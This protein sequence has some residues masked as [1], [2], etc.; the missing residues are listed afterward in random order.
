ME[1]SVKNF[2]IQ[3]ISNLLKTAE[4]NIELDGDCECV[5]G[6]ISKVDNIELDFSFE[7]D[8]DFILLKG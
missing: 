8:A 4:R 5:V 6:S 2:K 3:E 1:I 7:A